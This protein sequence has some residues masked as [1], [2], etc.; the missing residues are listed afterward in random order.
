M[1]GSEARQKSPEPPSRRTIRR[2]ISGIA[3]A[4]FAGVL[5]AA[6]WQRS[7]PDVLPLGASLPRLQYVARTG[8][9]A[10]APYAGGRTVVIVYE[11]TCEHCQAEL[12]AL[13]RELDRTAGDRIVLLTPAR[14]PEPDSAATWWPRLAAASNVEWARADLASLESAFGLRVVPMT[15]VFDS[16]GRLAVKYRGEV[17]ADVVFPGARNATGA[18]L[19]PGRGGVLGS[20]DSGA[21]P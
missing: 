10:L 19:H 7:Q 2:L 9:G 15:Y 20:H 18:R 3:L 11:A 5:V 13:N 4:V 1:T 8:A 12:T 16:R 14:G 17:S 21:R 6:A